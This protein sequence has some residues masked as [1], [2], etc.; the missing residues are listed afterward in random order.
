MTSVTARSCDNDDDDDWEY[1]YDQNENEVSSRTAA[2][3]C[4]IEIYVV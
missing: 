4:S 1:E 2:L 3:L